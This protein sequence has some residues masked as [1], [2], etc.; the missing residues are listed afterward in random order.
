M[1][2]IW[3]YTPSDAQLIPILFNSIK[4]VCLESFEKLSVYLSDPHLSES[5]AETNLKHNYP[6]QTLL[7][8]PAKI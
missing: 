2:P 6:Y 4:S 8:K 3:I 1:P 5:S 7:V